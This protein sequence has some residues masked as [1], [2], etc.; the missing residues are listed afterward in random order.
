ML[1]GAQPAGYLSIQTLVEASPLRAFVLILGGGRG[2]RRGY[3]RVTGK[4]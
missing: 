1:R 2:R 3:A 4:A